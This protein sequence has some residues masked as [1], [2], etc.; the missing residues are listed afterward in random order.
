VNLL[1]APVTWT[2]YRVRFTVRSFLRMS[3]P[4][5]SPRQ[6]PPDTRSQTVVE[7]YADEARYLR[8]WGYCGSKFRMAI[9]STAPA[10]TRIDGVEVVDEV[11]IVT[12]LPLRCYGLL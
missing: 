1:T 4:L 5:K 6:L 3:C 2:G 10:L 9:G 11:I 7:I 8:G 12:R